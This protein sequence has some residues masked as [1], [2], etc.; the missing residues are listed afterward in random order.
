LEFIL[1]LYFILRRQKNDI[2][3]SH[4]VFVLAVALWVLSNGVGFFTDNETVRLFWWRLAFPAAA[5]IAATFLY[6]SWSFPFSR[7]QITLERKILVF[8]PTILFLVLVF[9]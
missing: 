1:A 6:F 4:I 8:M 3:V 9:L 7:K 5:A 2:V